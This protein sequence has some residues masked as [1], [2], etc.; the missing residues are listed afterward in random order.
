[1]TETNKR[2][3]LFHINCLEHGGAERVVSNL[4]NR[5]AEAGYEVVV[6]VEWIGENEYVLDSRI[7]HRMIGISGS[8]QS[9]GRIS[10]YQTSFS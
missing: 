4:A 10:K 6:A 2:K 7:S 3:I 5:F 9:K 1:M 8:E